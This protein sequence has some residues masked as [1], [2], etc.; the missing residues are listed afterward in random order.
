MKTLSITLLV[1][2]ISLSM[3]AQ[4]DKKAD[5]IDAERVAYITTQLNLTTTEAQKF[6]PVYNE[7]VKEI[8][9]LK[10]EGITK[11]LEADNIDNLTDAEIT[12]MVDYKLI[13]EEK[14][15][16][17]RKKFHTKFKEVLPIR[18]VGKLYMAERGFKKELLNKMKE[19]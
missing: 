6:W 7:Y 12:A 1:C 4:A 15:L 3:F 19:K 9:T 17:I 14:Q 13:F 18:K 16:A 2:L 11:R 8:K 5:A 10:K